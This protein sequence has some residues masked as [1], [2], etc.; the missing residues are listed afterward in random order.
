[1]MFVLGVPII[2]IFKAGA[3]RPGVGLLHRPGDAAL[4]CHQP[5][6]LCGPDVLLPRVRQPAPV[7]DV[8]ACQ[9]R[10]LHGADFL[11]LAAGPSGDARLGG[12]PGLRLRVLRP[13]VLHHGVHPAPPRGGFG[14]FGTPVDG[15]ARVRGR[16]GRHGGGPRAFSC[17][18]RC[19]LPSARRS[20]KSCFAAAWAWSWR[21]PRAGSCASPRWTSSPAS[22]ARWG[23]KLGIVKPPRGRH[24]R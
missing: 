4:D 2:Q 19:S 12:H 6:V 18:C 24:A 3:F 14:F 11:V 13:A 23:M 9:L 17:S 5:A 16:A 20:S 1:M 21:S 10:A 15:R 7:H 8:R 22:C